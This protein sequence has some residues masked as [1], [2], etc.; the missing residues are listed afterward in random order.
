MAADRALH[1]GPRI[2]WRTYA[3]RRVSAA[4]AL[5]ATAA[6]LWLELGGVVG[7]DPRDVASLALRTALVSFV[8]ASVAFA[9]T[10]LVFPPRHRPSAAA[11]W[12][13]LLLLVLGALLIVALSLDAPWRLAANLLGFAS[14]G[15]PLVLFVLVR[16][17]CVAATDAALG[18]CLFA[19]VPAA[20]SVERPPGTL[21]FEATSP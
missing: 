12:P 1:A 18:L 21:D 11:A 20:T 6:A 16:A 8:L 19:L 2:G 13:P 14:V 10:A 15:A 9:V 3:S 17:G 7:S 5:F 4:L